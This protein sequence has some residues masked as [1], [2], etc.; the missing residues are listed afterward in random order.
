MRMRQ[1]FGIHN[2][3]D[4]EGTA[5]PRLIEDSFGKFRRLISPDC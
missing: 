2:A 3:T 4:D 1:K 5:Q